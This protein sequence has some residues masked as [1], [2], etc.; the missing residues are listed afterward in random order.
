MFQAPSIWG[1][2]QQPGT[3]ESRQLTVCWRHENVE[4]EGRV[5]VVRADVEG[6]GTQAVTREHVK[7]ASGMDRT[8]RSL[9][10]AI[11]EG[12]I[13]KKSMVGRIYGHSTARRRSCTRWKRCP[14][15]TG[16]C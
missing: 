7:R 11:R 5:R 2:T 8:C 13:E 16:A 9:V 15:Y 4:E 1:Q 6:E 14:S 3:R 10:I 12:F